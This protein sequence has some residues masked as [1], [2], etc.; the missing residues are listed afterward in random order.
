MVRV[1]SSDQ[2]IFFIAFQTQPLFNDSVSSMEYLFE[3]KD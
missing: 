1:K 3:R 2:Y